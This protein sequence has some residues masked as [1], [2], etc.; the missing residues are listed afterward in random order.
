MI[1]FEFYD[2]I[3][4][5]KHTLKLVDLQLF[6]AKFSFFIIISLRYFT[7][8]HTYTPKYMKTAYIVCIMS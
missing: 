7:H 2:E 4:F 1:E 3:T 6:M 8:T 5:L